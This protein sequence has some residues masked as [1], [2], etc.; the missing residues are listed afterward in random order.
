MISAPLSQVLLT[1][2]KPQQ[3]SITMD[4][5]LKLWINPDY[6]KEWNVTVVATVAALPVNPPPEY[7]HILDK[8]KVGD[9][10]C[11][12]YMVVASF[13]FADD[14]KR[15]MQS[16]EDNDYYKEFMNGKG[17][18]VRVQAMPKRSGIKGIIWAGVYTDKRGEFI[19]GVQG[20]ESTVERWLSQFPFGKTDT[21]SFNNYFEYNGI[22]YWKC[23]L[24]EIYAVRKRGHLVAIGDRVI[25]K[26][27]DEVLPDQYFIDGTGLPQKVVIRKQDRGRIISGGSDMG[28]KKDQII[29]FDP[30][31]AEKYK[32]FGKD[33]LLIKKKLILG[34]WN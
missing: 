33:Y 12:S 13:D 28:L 27:V 8:I 30:R 26:P 25:T 31:H 9:E 7:K 1:V 2:D 19:D 4:S 15:F 32:F 16:T 14:G 11:V 10:I 24:D 3:D 21:F 5:G 17:E 34:K 23:G 22:D 18:R 29:N 20:D 6:N